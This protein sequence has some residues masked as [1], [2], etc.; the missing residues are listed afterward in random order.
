MKRKATERRA[1]EIKPKIGKYQP[2]K[3]AE[4]TWGIMNRTTGELER[5]KLGHLDRYPYKWVIQKCKELNE[6]ED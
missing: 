5:N 2:H 4:E 1:M 6:K 3:I